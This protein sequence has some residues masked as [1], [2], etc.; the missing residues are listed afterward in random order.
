MLSKTPSA[1]AIFVVLK[2]EY[3]PVPTSF[4]DLSPQAVNDTAPQTPV[5][6]KANAAITDKT[7]FFILLP[8]F[9]TFTSLI[10]N[11]YRNPQYM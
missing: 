8:F 3:F 5:A 9:I 4:A 1:V 2:S 6:D 10:K 7:F 11:R